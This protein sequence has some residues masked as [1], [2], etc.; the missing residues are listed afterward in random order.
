MTF[1]IREV[2]FQGF[3]FTNSNKI[4]NYNFAKI[5]TGESFL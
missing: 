3:Q 2:I 4:L 1:I 5:P